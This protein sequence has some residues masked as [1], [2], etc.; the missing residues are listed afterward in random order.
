MPRIRAMIWFQRCR[1]AL[2]RGPAR[3]RAPRSVILSLR[4]E[5]ARQPSGRRRGGN[6]SNHFCAP[7]RDGIEPARR[8]S[9]RMGS[10]GAL[11]CSQWRPAAGIGRRWRALVSER[12]PR[13]CVRRGAGRCRRGRPRS[14]FHTDVRTP[15]GSIRFKDSFS[16][17]RAS[18][19]HSRASATPSSPLPSRATPNTARDRSPLS[20]LQNKTARRYRSP[21]P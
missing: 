21:S 6:T 18:A 12:A 19:P 9:V 15:A 16:P 4:A 2:R 20:P 8:S 10:A 3:Q 5:S 17:R 7:R 11:A 14:P 13:R 1:V